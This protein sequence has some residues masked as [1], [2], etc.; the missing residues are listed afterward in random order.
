MYKSVYDTYLVKGYL[1]DGAT[2]MAE[3]R[4]G[5]AFLVHRRHT[6]MVDPRGHFLGWRMAAIQVLDK[7]MG[8]LK[9]RKPFI[10]FCEFLA[11]Y[12]A[13]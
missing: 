12:P 11:H 10:E 6:V 3:R 1:M 4:D 5:K 13:F 2:K 8:V 9:R 7:I